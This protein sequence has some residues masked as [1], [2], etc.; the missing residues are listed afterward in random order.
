MIGRN[1]N[2]E[3]YMLEALHQAR[4]AADRGE[5][6]VGAVVVRDGIIIARAYNTR[7][8]GKMRFIMRS[9]RR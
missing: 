2:A 8:T 5:V 9:S 4:R 7:E 6:P 1:P 3:V